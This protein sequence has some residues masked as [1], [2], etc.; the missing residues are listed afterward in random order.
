MLDPAVHKVGVVF[1][2]GQVVE[3]DWSSFQD[4]VHIH[5]L[6]HAPVKRHMMYSSWAAN[7]EGIDQHLFGLKKSLKEGEELPELYRDKPSQV[8]SPLFDGW[9]YSEGK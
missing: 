8:S 3:F 6:F 5:T 4:P 2:I 1:G 9:G 7:G